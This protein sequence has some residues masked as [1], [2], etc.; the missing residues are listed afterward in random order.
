LRAEFWSEAENSKKSGAKIWSW[1]DKIVDRPTYYN[2]VDPETKKV[3]KQTEHHYRAQAWPISS[4]ARNPLAPK[5]APQ[6]SKTVDE[7][8]RKR[9][10]AKRRRQKAARSGRD[11]IKAKKL[12]ENAALLLAQN[13]AL[14]RLAGKDNEW[15]EVTRKGKL[16]TKAVQPTKGPEKKPVKDPRDGGSGGGP[17]GGGGGKPGPSGAPGPGSSGPGGEGKTDDSSKSPDVGVKP[18]SGERKPG[19]PDRTSPPKPKPGKK[20]EK[21]SSIGPSKVGRANHGPPQGK[22]AEE[23]EKSNSAPVTRKERRRAIYGPPKEAAKPTEGSAKGKE[24]EKPLKKRE[25][26]EIEVP[27]FDPDELAALYDQSVTE[28]ALTAQVDWMADQMGDLHESVGRERAAGRELQEQQVRQVS[29]VLTE[30]SKTRLDA[31]D[32]KLG[33]IVQRLPS[34]AK[35][36][37]GPSKAGE[38][39]LRGAFNK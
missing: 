5:P 29:A 25:T 10:A 23:A 34:Q 4:G 13:K 8:T 22:T 30:Q 15:T 39:K 17:S 26:L 33:Q 20:S 11:L 12:A 36:A 2:E 7:E 24:P 28:S 37:P 21:K 19:A 38:G 35:A 6:P 14:H 27:D 31:I 9:R 18:E 1:M 3:V 32:A 16:I